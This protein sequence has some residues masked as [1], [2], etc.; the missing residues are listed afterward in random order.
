MHYREGSR[1]REFEP[2][3]SPPP[4][5][6]TL[7]EI[8]H[9]ALFS[10]ADELKKE[11]PGTRVEQEFQDDEPRAILWLVKSDGTVLWKEF[12]ETPFS[13]D[14]PERD[15]EYLDAVRRYQHMAIHYPG[16]MM[17]EEHVTRRI[18]DLWTRIEVHGIPSDVVIQG[19]LYGADGHTMTGV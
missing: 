2:E 17:T 19:F 13:A 18:T 9:H 15:E 10:R 7:V 6:P 16:L 11:N 4:A 1:E 5:I 12:V 8:V 14:R 3:I